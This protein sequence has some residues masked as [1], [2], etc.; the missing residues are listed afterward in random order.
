MELKF[1]LYALYDK[2]SDT[3]VDTFIAQSDG[4]AVR[5]TLLTLRVPIRDSEIYQIGTIS[6][7]I[8]TDKLS[9]FKSSVGFGYIASP[10]LVSWESY[11]FPE[12]I[13]DAVAPL[14]CSPDEVCEITKNFIKEG[15]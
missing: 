8:E 5:K 13:A 15:K 1:N 3:L 4:V 9:D 11:K 7:F 12:N 6:R 2:V 14:G 10:R